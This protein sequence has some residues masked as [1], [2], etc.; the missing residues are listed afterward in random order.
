MYRKFAQRDIRSF[1]RRKGPRRLS[2]RDADVRSETSSIGASPTARRR[3][4]IWRAA[5]Q[6]G[7]SEVEIRGLRFSKSSPRILPRRLRRC[8]AARR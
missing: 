5:T 4:R 6:A 2:F 1:G 8:A 3:L 7:M